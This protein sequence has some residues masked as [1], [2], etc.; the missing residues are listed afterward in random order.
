MDKNAPALDLAAI[1]ATLSD[2]PGVKLTVKGEKTGA[3]VVWLTGDTDAHADTIQAA[4]GIWSNKK[5]AYYIKPGKAGAAAPADK[6]A[7]PAPQLQPEP[8]AAPCTALVPVYKFDLLPA[9]A[10]RPAAEE[11]QE[12]NAPQPWKKCQFFT[13]RR[14]E[15]TKQPEACKM[16]G[17]TDGIY[18]YYTTGAVWFAIHPVYGLSVA[19]APTRKAA[20]QK[21]L[22]LSGQVRRWLDK[23]AGDARMQKFAALVKSANDGDNVSLF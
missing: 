12:A 13:V 17:Y 14:N 8:A 11:A 18:R 16:T 1:K 22:E 23:A 7:A 20:Q 6:P 10:P 15:S 5:R 9:P 2:L 3:P 21:A 4:G 19:D